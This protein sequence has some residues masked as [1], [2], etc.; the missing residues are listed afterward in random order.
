[1]F[2][3]EE[4]EKKMSKQIFTKND[5]MKLSRHRPST[6]MKWR[7]KKC[8]WKTT[9]SG[10]QMDNLDLRRCPG[11]P[12]RREIWDF[13]N[14]DALRAPEKVPTLTARDGFEINKGV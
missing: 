8:R 2:R 4:K 13:L 3:N 9:E 11:V 6:Q 12:N 7:V 14:S 1:M 10:R 5:L